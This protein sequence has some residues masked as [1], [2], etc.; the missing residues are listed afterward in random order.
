MRKPF[1]DTPYRI[2]AHR[3]MPCSFPENTLI[4]F[5]AALAAGANVIETDARLTSDGRIVLVHDETAQRMTGDIRKIRDLSYDE[6]SK[7]D[8]GYCFTPD[9]GKSFPF[10]SAGV[11]IMTLEELLD[12]FPSAKFNIDLK[13]CSIDLADRFCSV[14][15][16]YS[17][18][19]RVLAASFHHNVIKRVRKSVPAMA[20]AFS[21]REAM[22][23]FFLSRT[24]LIY[25][26]KTFPADAMQMPEYIGG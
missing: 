16:K 19:D 22:L 5:Q 4:S 7:L 20:T 3:G 11:T 14:I 2:N 26:K 23:I 15:K 13:D 24:G 9:A 12:H 17:A 6:I 25:F 21:S 18:Q 8:A 10:R 1:F